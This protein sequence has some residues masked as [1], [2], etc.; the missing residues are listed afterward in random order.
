MLAL[1]VSI[2]NRTV[3]D[4]TF[5]AYVTT[6]VLNTTS[7]TGSVLNLLNPCHTRVASLQCSHSVYK[8]LIAELRAVQTTATLWKRCAIV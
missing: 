5:M 2:K 7:W 3:S 1:M 8:T 6:L 4:R